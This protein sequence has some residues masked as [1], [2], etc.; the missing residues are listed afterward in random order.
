MIF[1][2]LGDKIRQKI[3]LLT[4]III[5]VVKT[6]YANLIINEVMAAP[7]DDESLNEWVELYN[8]GSEAINVSGFLFGDN[9]GN[10][11]IEGGLYRGEGT[12]IPAYGYAIMT[13]H[14]TRVYDNFNYSDYAIKL[15][16]DDDSVGNGLKNSGESLYLY[17]NSMQLIDR[18]DYNETEKGNCFAFINGSW[19]ESFCTAGYPNNGSIAYY[20]ESSECDWEIEILI[21]KTVFDNKDDFNFKARASKIYGNAANITGKIRIEDLFGNLVKE[22]SPWTEESSTYHRTSY[23]YSPSL[24]EGKAYIITSSLEVSCNDENP[25]N[26]VEQ[27]IITIKGNSY[28]NSSLIKIEDV[29]DL[30]RDDVARFGQT[31]RVKL[32]AYKGDTA[33]EVVTVWVEDD[34]NKIS[35]QS[36]FNVYNKFTESDITIPIQIKPN[37]DEEYDEGRYTIKAEGL[38]AYVEKKII[39]EG[40][41]EDLCETRFVSDGSKRSKIYYEL[42]DWPLEIEA[43]KEFEIKV[44]IENPDDEEHEIEAWSYVYRGSKSYSDG[45]ESNSKNLV[46]RGESSREIVLKNIIGDAEPGDYNLM[47]KIV[48]DGQKTENKITKKIRVSKKADDIEKEQIKEDEGSIELKGNSE[49]QSTVL[50]S[51]KKPIIVYESSTEKASN[52]AVFILVFAL[53]AYSGILTFR[54]IG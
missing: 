54:K 24:T 48:K 11:T 4:I 41:D 18:M 9:S 33:K 21:N 53:A 15:Y 27:K 43:E 38:D 29:Y 19:Q 17:D 22:Y 49:E 26:D 6:A 2:L 37:C 16:V 46:V 45:R 35:K 3:F 47:V 51:T 39:L 50:E 31:I 8:N 28:G 12:I 5:I 14:S 30:G 44:N 1:I 36:K 40:I 10:D 23:E 25:R 20:E 13:D 32:K 34:E 52:L 42:S 7:F